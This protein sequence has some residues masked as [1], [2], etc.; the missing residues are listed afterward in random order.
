MGAR[1]L[2]WWVGTCPAAG[3]S[4]A[5]AS[6]NKSCCVCVLWEGHQLNQPSAHLLLQAPHTDLRE[7]TASE[8][9]LEAVARAGTV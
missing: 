9:V 1:S 7:L 8:S 2:A 3:R 4:R 5:V 6:E